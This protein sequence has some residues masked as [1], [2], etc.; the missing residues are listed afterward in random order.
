MTFA[1]DEWTPLPTTHP[2]DLGVARCTNVGTVA[3]PLLP[4]LATH[5]F[6]AEPFNRRRL[7][8]RHGNLRVAQQCQ[9]LIC[10]GCST[11]NRHNFKMIKEAANLGV[12]KEC[13]KREK[14]PKNR[15]NTRDSAKH[16]KPSWDC[17]CLPY[18]DDSNG[19]ICATHI[20][21]YAEL[22]GQRALRCIFYRRQIMHHKPVAKAKRWTTKKGGRTGKLRHTG[23]YWRHPR[24]ELYAEPHCICGRLARHKRIG[25][26][27][28]PQYDSR[29]KDLNKDLV[30]SCALCT[31]IPGDAE[32]SNPRPMT[33]ETNDDGVHIGP[34]LLREPKLIPAGAARNEG[35]DYG[36]EGWVRRPVVVAPPRSGVAVAGAAPGPD[37]VVDAAA[38]APVTASVTAPITAPVIPVVPGPGTVTGVAS[39]SYRRMDANFRRQGRLIVE[40]GDDLYNG[41]TETRN[42]QYGRLAEYDNLVTGFPAASEEQN[43]IRQERDWA[44]AAMDA[45]QAVGR[46][47]DTASIELWDAEQDVMLEHAG[48][49]EEEERERIERLNE[50]TLVLDEAEVALEVA[51]E[52]LDEAARRVDRPQYVRDEHGV[53]S[54]GKHFWSTK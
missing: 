18:P 36:M 23:L 41:L 40:D 10:L 20:E 35:Q 29:N 49:T 13:Y 52:E 28:I 6:S 45:T 8:D 5:I 48:G 21:T 34:G 19:G 54:P 3:Q 44:W 37:V 12:C 26:Q 38:T 53:D 24:G 33:V 9:Q 50:A 30:R 47:V 31:S 43:L 27:D 1:L 16:G 25:W 32:P 46:T 14:N 22:V 4:C 2:F 39:P 7:P 51:G 17:V 11:R 15:N 42:E